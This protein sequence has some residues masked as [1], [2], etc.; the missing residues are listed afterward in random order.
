MVWTQTRLTARNILPAQSCIITSHKSHPGH[1]QEQSGGPWGR[2]PGVKLV[3][4]SFNRPGVITRPNG[5]LPHSLINLCDGILWSDDVLVIPKI[6]ME[7]G[8]ESSWSTSQPRSQSLVWLPASDLG[9]VMNEPRVN[10]SQANVIMSREPHGVSSLAD[11]LITVSCQI[12]ESEKM[13]PEF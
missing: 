1:Y 9:V 10:C 7:W 3:K 4:G 12:R 2:L 6:C 13:S 8:V 11:E 5:A